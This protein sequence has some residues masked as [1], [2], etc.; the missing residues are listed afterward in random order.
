M[1]NDKIYIKILV[2]HLEDYS[3]HPQSLFKEHLK[4]DIYDLNRYDCNFFPH[5]KSD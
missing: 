4:N 5:G 1:F 2:N 3:F